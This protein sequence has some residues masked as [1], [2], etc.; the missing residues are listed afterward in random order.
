MDNILKSLDISK[1]AGEDK[2]SGKY[3]R[4]AAEVIS[5]H[6]TYIMN[7][8]LKVLLSRGRTTSNWQGSYS[9]I[10][11]ETEMKKVTIDRCQSYRL[12][13]KSLKNCL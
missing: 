6:L 8:S 9:Y 12:H 10:K 3:L 1:S 7:S 13:Q 4:D 11:N 2:I 5:S